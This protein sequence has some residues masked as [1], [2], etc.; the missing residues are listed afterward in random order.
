M[1]M[2]WKP[3]FIISVTICICLYSSAPATAQEKQEDPSLLSIDRIFNSMDF[4]MDRVMPIRW[5]EGGNAY[6]TFERSETVKFG[7]NVIR[8]E[9]STGEKSIL[10]EAEKFIPQGEE[11]PLSFDDLA[12]SEDRSKLLLFTNTKRV[13][14]S[15]TRGDYWLLDRES[16]SL[17]QLGQGLPESSLMFAK[18]SPDGTKVAYVSKNNIY[19]ED[20]SNHRITQL[21]FDGTETMINGTF[22]WVYEEE[23]HCRDGFSWSPDGTRIA[24]WQLDASGIRTF[25]MINNTDSL[26]PFTIPV[27]YPK[28]GEPP[29]SCR[30]GVIPSEGG[31]VTWLEIPG[32]T[33][34]HYLPRMMWT[35]ET[36]Q[37]LVQQLNRKQNTNRLWLCNSSNG[38]ADNIFT[39]EDDAWLDVVDDWR[40]IDKGKAFLWIS[41][42]DG[43]RHAYRIE[44]RD[45][46]SSLITKGD[47]DVISVKGIDPEEEYLYFIASPENATQR[48]LYR[49]LM[50]G[51]RKPELLSP[52][53][54]SG[55]H[56]YNMSPNTHF[57]Y[58]TFSNANTPPVTSMISLPNHKVL[59]IIADNQHFKEVI[60]KI[61]NQPREFFKVKTSEGVEMDGWMM[62]PPDFN[63]KRKYPVLFSVYGEPWGQTAT[64]SWDY[65]LLWNML[66]A[67]KGYIVMTMDNRGTPCPKG[68]E[69][70]KSIYRKIGVINARDQALATREITRWKFVDPDRIAV[71][72]W[73]GGGSMTLN[74]MFR[75][76]EIYQTGMAVAPVTNELLYDNIYQER[77]MGLIPE[78]LAD[79]IEGSPITYAKNLEGNLL[80]VHGTGDDNVHYQNTEQLVNELVKNNKQFQVM[81]YPNRSHGIYEGENTSRHL[82]TLLLDYLLEHTEPGGRK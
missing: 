78:N 21:T 19:T 72:G 56:S 38:R 6:T 61:K 59:R 25:Y 17:S 69:W 82:Y 65:D 5:I 10:V 58:H 37:I 44:V 28:V 7:R 76:P 77:Y 49:T 8:Y 74:L 36:G 29:S 2:I 30:I 73:S 50:D 32:D 62:K 55:T 34:D 60:S 26:Y 81:P 20:L 12:W 51:T 31:K 9:S 41:E 39:D 43:W 70:R 27:Q 71:W 54:M 22:D 48:Y 33:Q 1:K 16:G 80:I 45:G 75:Y 42:R 13:W 24:F 46:K 57:A 11:N 15:N 47:Y 66:I 67:Q 3:L 14:R 53:N 40:W 52:E 35:Q 63:P 18:F 79:F 68:R 64:D 4:M 23:F